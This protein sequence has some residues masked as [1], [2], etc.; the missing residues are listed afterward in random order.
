VYFIFLLLLKDIFDSES[1]NSVGVS[2]LPLIILNNLI[3]SITIEGNLD[4]VDEYS[5][6]IDVS[7]EGLEEISFYEKKYFTENNDQNIENL[8]DNNEN[9]IS[10]YSKIIF[11]SFLHPFSLDY[12]LQSASHEKDFVNYSLLKPKV[13]FHSTSLAQSSSNSF[14]YEGKNVSS[15]SES[16]L[17][18]DIMAEKVNMNPSVVVLPEGRCI[19]YLFLLLYFYYYY[20]G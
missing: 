11:N 19:F 17:T 8:D 3:N 20:F 5:D 12:F 15:K 1:M 9:N 18:S 10:N 6:S 16:A 13:K 4:D 2:Y 7:E 14:N